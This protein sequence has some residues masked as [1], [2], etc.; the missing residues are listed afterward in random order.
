MDGNKEIVDGFV[1]D[2]GVASF[3]HVGD[4][5][6]EIPWYYHRGGDLFGHDRLEVGSNDDAADSTGEIVDIRSMVMRDADTV[7][8]YLS[9]LAIDFIVMAV[10]R[11]FKLVDPTHTRAGRRST[12][13]SI[14][15]RV[16]L[17]FLGRLRGVSRGSCYVL[18]LARLLTES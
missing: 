3:D 2:I 6:L 11:H 8:N 13:T 4:T 15:I 5:R 7:T 18:F 16:S 9:K 10:N 12:R 14:N 1:R 17:G